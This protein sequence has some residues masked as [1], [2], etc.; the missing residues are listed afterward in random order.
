MTDNT[1]TIT[2][3]ELTWL[4]KQLDQAKAVRKSLTFLADLLAI[5]PGMDLDECEG[6]STIIGQLAESLEVTP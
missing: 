6:L 4:H 2:K 3:D 5:N 1:V